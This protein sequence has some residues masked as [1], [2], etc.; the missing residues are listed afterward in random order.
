M[1]SAI[2]STCYTTHINIDVNSSIITPFHLKH[3][4]FS[5][6]FFFFAFYTPFAVCCC[7]TLF[8]NLLFHTQG[9]NAII[10]HIKQMQIRFSIKSKPFSNNLCTLNWYAYS[11][12]MH[13]TITKKKIIRFFLFFYWNDCKRLKW[14]VFKNVSLIRDSDWWKRLVNDRE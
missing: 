5:L 13:F 8:T 11:K 14:T 6:F 7:C 12:K 3:T 1:L 9:I 2:Q 10:R 4:D